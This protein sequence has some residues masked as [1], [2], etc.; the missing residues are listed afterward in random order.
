MAD[1]IVAC[2]FTRLPPLP[3]RAN[4]D[5]NP[6]L[7]PLILP[8]T[9]VKTLLAANVALVARVLLLIAVRLD[10]T[11]NCACMLD[12]STATVICDTNACSVA[13]ATVIL[14]PA[15]VITAVLLKAAPTFLMRLTAML[16]VVV[17]VADT[18]PLLILFATTVND[19]AIN[20][21]N[22][23]FVRLLPMATS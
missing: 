8:I 11:D 15:A 9:T 5:V 23:I 21:S 20:A 22:S 18:M 14:S 3:A 17:D 13:V 4:A 19:P 12:I 1:A 2:P 6:A 10:T 16:A 7:V